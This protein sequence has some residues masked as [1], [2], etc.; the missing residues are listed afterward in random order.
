MTGKKGYPEEMDRAYGK[1]Q[2]RSDECALLIRVKRCEPRV[3]RNLARK[4]L[5]ELPLNG[6]ENILFRVSPTLNNWP[7][8]QDFDFTV[9]LFHLFHLSISEKSK[10]C[11]AFYV[12]SPELKRNSF[13]AK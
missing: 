6:V 11:T 5:N 13:I 9:G 10:K 1:S 3:I 8:E 12:S 2:E 4:G 7:N